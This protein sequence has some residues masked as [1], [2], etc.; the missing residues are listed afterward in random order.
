MEAILFPLVGNDAAQNVAPVTWD[1][2]LKSLNAPPNSTAFMGVNGIDEDPHAHPYARTDL[3][4][5]TCQ[6]SDDCGGTG[7]LCARATGAA[8][9]CATV[10]LDD[11]GCPAT[12]H[13]ASVS[14]G[15][16]AARACVQ[17]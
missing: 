15:A 6:S 4:G 11:A 8:K 10:C 17:R 3:L 13:C 12:H 16:A 1:D 2:I 7:N 14:S 5:A 9:V